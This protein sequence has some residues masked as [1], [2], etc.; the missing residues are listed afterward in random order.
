MF[1]HQT[2]VNVQ[3]LSTEDH[4]VK[5][6]TFYVPDDCSYGGYASTD[7]IFNRKGQLIIEKPG[8]HGNG[9]KMAPPYTNA[10][11]TYHAN[12]EFKTIR[13]FGT[14]RDNYKYYN[15]KG[16]IIKII[17]NYD[18]DYHST[19]EYDDYGNLIYTE[20]SIILLLMRNILSFN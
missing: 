12:G 2:M 11:F 16:Q 17:E 13:T 14:D 20:Y 15:K 18:G 7:S 3:V 8:Y 1:L 5:R 19:Y 4:Q 10:E 9:T 6:K